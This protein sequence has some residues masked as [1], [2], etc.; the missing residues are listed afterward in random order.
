MKT[1]LKATLV[2]TA[3]LVAN[4]S[5]AQW[6]KNRIKGN[7][8][9]TT[10]TVSTGDYDTVKVVGS[11]DVHLEA[12]NEGNIT[13]ETDSNILESVVIEEQ[14]GT[15]KIKMKK[16]VSYKSK[17]GV[18]VT[19]PFESLSEVS[20]T[21]SG[22][23]DSKD[24]LKGS[25]LKVNVTGSGDVVLP[26]AMSNVEA[27]I[28]GSGDVGLSGETQNLEVKVTG[29]GD[30]SG[31]KLTSQNT[32]VSVSGSGDARVVAKDNLVARVYGSGDIEYS[33]NPNKRDTKTSGS[34]D[35]TN[36]N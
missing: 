32:E 20:L 7:G 2:T 34:G 15:L 21:G 33:G 17:H 36:V 35:I 10:K 18:H 26:V 24:A 29:S 31:S 27:T 28:T 6:G 30:F 8:N 9:I 5:F 1:I 14:N 16:G 25:N 4:Q 11:M 13:I 22:D 3:L 12:G 23:V 19:V